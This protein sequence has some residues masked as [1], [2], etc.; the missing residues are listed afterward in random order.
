M[1]LNAKIK[2]TLRQNYY[3]LQAIAVPLRRRGSVGI[4]PE[5]KFL[6]SH[7]ATDRLGEEEA[8]YTRTKIPCKP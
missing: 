6:A 1:K 3:S 4:I 2:P 7:S 8:N 5:L